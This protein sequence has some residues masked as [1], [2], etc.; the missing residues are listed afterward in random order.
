MFAA[1]KRAGVV[2]QKSPVQAETDAY[3]L[4]EE[5]RLRCEQLDFER[6]GIL[7]RP[8]LRILHRQVGLAGFLANS[9]LPS[10]RRREALAR[11]RISVVSDQLEDQ[12]AESALAA[13][14][15]RAR[16]AVEEGLMI[17][18]LSDHMRLAHVHV[19]RAQQVVANH[20]QVTRSPAA[21]PAPAPWRPTAS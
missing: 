14:I 11:A 21:L 3:E 18:G 17:P 12:D 19:L 1:G 7:E 8:P 6:E 4:L 20:F 2:R 15:E 13:L 9:N 5:A 16:E 10:R